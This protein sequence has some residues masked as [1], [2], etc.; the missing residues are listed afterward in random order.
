MKLYEVG[1]IYNDP[2]DG[3]CLAGFR[4]EE[5]ALSFIKNKRFILTNEFGDLPEGYARFQENISMKIVNE[6]EIKTDKGTIILEKN[7]NIKVFK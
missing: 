1:L 3:F 7:D 4:T 6:V 2:K 5:D